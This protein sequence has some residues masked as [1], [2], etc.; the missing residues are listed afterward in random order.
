MTT[1]VT[2]KTKAVLQAYEDTFRG[3]AGAIVLTDLRQAY[4]DKSDFGEDGYEDVP[5]EFRPWVRAGERRVVMAI[6][7]AME[8]NAVAVVVPDESDTTSDRS[9]EK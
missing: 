5:P 8:L 9:N 1:S 6:Q 7:R 2:A 4:H 3:G